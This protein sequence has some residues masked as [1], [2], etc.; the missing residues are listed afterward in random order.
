MVIFIC[1]NLCNDM[2]YQEVDL[3]TNQNLI[4]NL[5]SFQKAKI[6]LALGMKFQGGNIGDRVNGVSITFMEYYL[7]SYKISDNQ[8]GKSSFYI[9]PSVLLNFA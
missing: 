8:P 1:E 7:L 9:L 3:V 6:S 5:L 4:L 2:V